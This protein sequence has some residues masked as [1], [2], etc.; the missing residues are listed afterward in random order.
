MADTLYK[1]QP[2]RT[3]YL[4]GFS[5]LGAGAAIHDATPTGFQVSGVFRDPADFAVVVLWDADD[6]FNH[7]TLKYLPDTN[8][9]GLTLEFDVTYTNLM[10]LNCAKYPTIDWPYLDVQ[11]PDGTS[12]QIRLSDYAQTIANSDPVASGT[13]EITGANLQPYDRL[14]LWY[15]NIAYDYIVPGQ[16][17]WSVQFYI[18]APG[19]T[20]TIAVDTRSYSYTI[21]GTDTAASLVEA[22]VGAINAGS[23]DPEIAASAGAQPGQII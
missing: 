11:F 15:L 7:P 13:L 8:F 4:R 16:T 9:A 23:G 17:S 18:D 19:K 1:L 5:D 12:R 20:Y 10:P 6:F 14:T 22:L 21:T 3:M 2:D